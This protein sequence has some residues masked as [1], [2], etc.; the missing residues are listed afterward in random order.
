MGKT[1]T[2]EGIEGVAK[3]KNPLRISHPLHKNPLKP[4]KRDSS[5]QTSSTEFGSFPDFFS[6]LSE[7]LSSIHTSIHYFDPGKVEESLYIVA[8]ETG[9]S[10]PVCHFQYH[11]EQRLPMCLP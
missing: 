7:L 11:S 6:K 5:T 9:L 2:N 1:Q 3:P 4:G 10:C 8:S